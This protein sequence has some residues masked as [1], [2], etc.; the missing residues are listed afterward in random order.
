MFNIYQESKL[1][2]QQNLVDCKILWK[3]AGVHYQL[4]VKRGKIIGI[5]GP[6]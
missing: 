3:K 2:D 6:S 5:L 1:T 4:E